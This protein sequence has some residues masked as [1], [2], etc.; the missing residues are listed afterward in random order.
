M[1][2]KMRLMHVYE[3]SIQ[4][5]VVRILSADISFFNLFSDARLEFE[6]YLIKSAF[7][8]NLPSS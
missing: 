6:I 5:T 1:I 4:S 7:F 8:N 2:E 3:R